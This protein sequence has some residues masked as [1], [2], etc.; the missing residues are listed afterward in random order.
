MLL[1]DL[2]MEAPIITV[3]RNSDSEDNLEINLGSLQL[4][5]VVRVVQ[6]D[7]PLDPHA[8]VQARCTATVPDSHH[9]YWTQDQSTLYMGGLEFYVVRDGKAGRNIVQQYDAGTQLYMTRPLKDPAQRVPGFELAIEMPSLRAC[10]D[11]VEYRMITTLASE[12]TSEA[13]R[14]PAGAVWLAQRLH[15]DGAAGEHHLECVCGLVWCVVRQRRYWCM[16]RLD[17][18]DAPLHGEAPALQLGPTFIKAGDA[19]SVRVTVNIG[20]VLCGCVRNCDGCSCA[21]V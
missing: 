6:G 2:S 10:L 12:N 19:I 4:S 18:V 11:D 9:G 8:V 1:L 16:H 13:L 15:T 7:G 17:A 21:I 5:N 20:Q 3:P 14:T